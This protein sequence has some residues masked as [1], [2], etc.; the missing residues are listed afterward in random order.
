MLQILTTLAV[1]SYMAHMGEKLALQP[2]PTAEYF[3]AL[4]PTQNWFMGQSDTKVIYLA[5]KIQKGASI[6]F[7]SS[8]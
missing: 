6:L 3:L 5:C 1:L 8:L 2:R 4:G 7:L